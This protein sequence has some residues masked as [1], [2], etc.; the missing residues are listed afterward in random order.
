MR[1]PMQGARM[2]SRE[3]GALS[4]LPSFPFVFSPFAVA[5]ELD[6]APRSVSRA[7][8]GRQQRSRLVV[9]MQ[10]LRS[11][12]RGLYQPRVLELRPSGRD[13]NAHLGALGGT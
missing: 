9:L 3:V 8:R 4:S 5:A 1:S 7:F 10:C 12:R 13:G 6:E 2:V 11:S